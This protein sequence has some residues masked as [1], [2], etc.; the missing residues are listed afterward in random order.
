MRS[1]TCRFWA[2]AFVV[3]LLVCSLFTTA[4]AQ[5]IQTTPYSSPSLLRG[6]S[7]QD[8]A[9]SNPLRAPGTSG[10]WSSGGSDS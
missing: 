4:G 5:G 1:I 9:P 6:L 7:G 2:V 8:M 3:C 10:P